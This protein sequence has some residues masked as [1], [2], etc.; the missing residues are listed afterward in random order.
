MLGVQHKMI[1]YQIV[2]KKQDKK[3]L[4]KSFQDFFILIYNRELTDIDWEHQFIHSPYED[5]AL[6]LAFDGDQIVG[7]ALMIPQKFTI[8]NSIGSYLLW[9]TSAIKKEYRQFGIYA[10]LLSMQRTYA[11]EHN[12]DFIFAFPNKL[13]YPVVKL[14]GGFKDFYKIN[15]IK[16]TIDNLDFEQVDNSLVLDDSFT[17]WRFEHKEYLF[18]ETKQYILITK[19]YNNVLDV[20]AIYPKEHWDKNIT[21]LPHDLKDSMIITASTFVKSLEDVEVLD[22]LNGTYF[23]INKNIEYARVK[24]NLLMSDVF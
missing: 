17:Q 24:L 2:R 4:Q 6:F 13:A 10:E 16:T 3:K 20:L 1:K 21:T 19:R 23:P 12:A 15:L 11:Q 9:T 8:N 22:Q 7:S 18:Y 14:F 5:S